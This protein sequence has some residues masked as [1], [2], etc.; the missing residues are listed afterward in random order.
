[1]NHHSSLMPVLFL[2]H[3]SPVATL[4]DAPF[5][6]ALRSLGE[7]L[8]RPRSILMV[9]A[10]WQTPGVRVLGN[11]RPR[12]IYD[13][14]G[15]PAELSQLDYPAPGSPELA[16]RVASL[17]S[18]EQAAL[19]ESW[20]FDHG[21]WTV[22]RHLFPAADIPVTQLS[23]SRRWTPEQH[24]EAAKKLRPLREEGVLLCGSGNITHNLSILD[25]EDPLAEPLPAAVK[26][27]EKIRDRL[28]AK[29]FEAIGRVSL[30]DPH[31]REFH[32]TVDHYLP[33]VYCCGA[34]MPDDAV[35]FPFVGFRHASLSMR[36]VQFA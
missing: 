24:F 3:G 22:L 2:A 16:R 15:F 30:K 28:E 9:S 17:L 26:F 14:S 25:W 8:P 11:A 27:D 10:H 12:M 35:T 13:F 32:P 23:L 5:I 21:T 36:F 4:S 19:D 18:E 31:L 33:L 29:D 1:M 7:R 34:A 20:G 6:G